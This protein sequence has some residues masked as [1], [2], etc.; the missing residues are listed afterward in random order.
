MYIHRCINILLSGLITLFKRSI[1]ASTL[2]CSSGCRLRLNI[3]AVALFLFLLSQPLHALTINLVYDPDGED[4][5]DPCESELIIEGDLIKEVP[6]YAACRGPG[7]TFLNRTQLLTAIMESA[8]DYWEDIIRDDHTIEIRYWWLSPDKGAPDANVLMRDLF[9]KP[10]SSRIR[11]S[12]DLSYFYDT[13]PDEDEEYDLRPRLYRTTHSTEQTEAFTGEPPEILEVSYNGPGPGDDLWTA[14]VHEMTHA[15]GMAAIDTMTCDEMFDPFYH[16]DPDLTGGSEM[17][18]KAYEFTEK[19]DEGNV[20]GPAFDCAHLAL[21]NID[22][23]KPEGQE[24][25]PVGGIFNDPSPVE[26]FTVGECASHQALMWQGLFPLSRTKP[27]TVDI[28]AVEQAGNWDEIDLPRKYSIGSG[29]WNSGD[30]WLGNRIPDS[31]DDIYIVNRLPLFFVTQIDVADDGFANNVFIS[32]ENELSVLNSTLEVGETVTIAG[33]GSDAGPIN[34][35]LPPPPD[36]TPIGIE[37]PFSTVFVGNSGILKTFDMVI[38]PGGRLVLESSGLARA[39]TLM[40]S[41]VISG[42][43]MVRVAGGLENTRIISADGGKLTL[44]TPPADEVIEI[45]V[46]DLDG[47]GSFGNRL[48]SIRAVDG[49][50]EFDAI[51]ADAVHAA[52]TVGEGRTLTFTNGWQQGESPGPILTTHRL[53]MEGGITG[54]QIQ[55]FS[56]LGGRVFPDGFGIFTSDVLLEPTAEINLDIAGL[57]PGSQHDQLVINQDIEFSGT[58]RVMFTDGFIPSFTDSF[59][60]ISY[61]GHIGEFDTFEVVNL[62]DVSEGG[63]VFMLEYGENELVLNVGLEGG[64][65]GSPAC[66]GQTASTQSGIHGGISNAAQFHGFNSVKEFMDAL[67]EFCDG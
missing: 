65:P 45:P 8:A 23:C 47:P 24:D 32:D 3:I 26:G 18:I 50:L 53:I 7:N 28:L 48:A 13:T 60:L 2:N 33:P 59:P 42:S 25:T 20:I 38:E 19:D 54:A 9:G 55:G 52:V 36:D 4:A 56:V 5:V 15:L 58:L 16:I 64:T 27:G 46:L 10:V 62:E 14:V 51:I 57:T 63:L 21:G 49:D 39:G 6:K 12:V 37:G 35:D 44:F 34:P 29:D 43:G 1:S 67:K 61:S 22:A 30:T 40:N 66:N 41:G 11:I 31:G 17:S